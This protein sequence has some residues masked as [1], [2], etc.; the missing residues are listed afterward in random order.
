M[1]N[2]NVRDCM[3]VA[4]LFFFRIDEIFLWF[5][6]NGLD[7]WVKEKS[8]A[9]IQSGKR[10]WD[11]VHLRRITK[12]LHF[13]YLKKKKYWMNISPDDLNCIWLCGVYWQKGY[14][15]VPTSVEIKSDCLKTLYVCVWGWRWRRGMGIET[16]IISHIIHINYF[17]WD[18]I[19]ICDMSNEYRDV[20]YLP[21]YTYKLFFW[22]CDM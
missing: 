3:T 16:Y 11:S 22:G 6:E 18:V 14:M 15:E 5:S 17:C 20:Y 1:G 2:V 12:T 13:H 9:L 8:S 10:G 4:L 19:C 7:R 21:R